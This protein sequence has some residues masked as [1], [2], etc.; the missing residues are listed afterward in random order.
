MTSPEQ[1]PIILETKRLLLRHQQAADL[2]PLMAL[3]TD[4]AVTRYLG[5]PR[6]RARLQAALEETAQ[7]PAGERYDLWPLIE[8][9]TGRVVGHCGLLDKEVAGRTEI[10]VTYILAASVWGQGY[11]TEIGRALIRYAFE[12]MGVARVIALIEPDNAASEQVALKIGMR[13]EKEV[14]RPSGSV[15]KMYVYERDDT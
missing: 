13:L 8:T 2:E 11:A 14:V 1:S 3:W 9:G 6:D 15:R 5:G 4:P 10:E 12:T 7:N